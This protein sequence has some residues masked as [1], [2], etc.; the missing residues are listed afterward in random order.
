VV[1][2]DVDV[3]VEV[4]GAWVTSI[5]TVAVGVSTLVVESPDEGV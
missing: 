2:V 4:E 5:Q 3:S 1:E